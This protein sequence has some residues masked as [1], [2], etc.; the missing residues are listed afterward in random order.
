MAGGKPRDEQAGKASIA[1]TSDAN[2]LYALGRT[3]SESD[4][5]QRQAEELASYSAALLDRVALRAGQSAID[6][7]CGPRGI[8]DLLAER[9]SP[10]GRVVGLDADPRHTAMAADFVTG[11]G[12]LGVEII[13]AD[14]RRSGL[15]SESFDVVHARTLLINVPDP[16]EVVAEMLRLVKPGGWVASLEPDTEHVLC[17]PPNAAFERICELFPLVYARNGADPNLGRR[18]AELLR[19]AG[20]EDVGVEVRVQ[21]YPPG[22]SRRTLRLDL[23]ASMRPHILELELATDA[24][25]DELDA[26]ARAHIDDPRTI[27][28]S[29]LTFLSWG[30]KP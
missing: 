11:H 6:L 17:Y 12:L 8:L 3:C 25:L 30:R 16:E 26:S 29:G 14:A 20:L 19:N 15:R 9:T 2:A 27:V 21:S 24:E 22:H 1:P 7:G 5:L 23:L 10:D 13:T 18:V 28:V 4:R